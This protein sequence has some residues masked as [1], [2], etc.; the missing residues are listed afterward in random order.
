M[1]AKDCFG[2]NVSV[3]DRVRIVGFSDAFMVSLL[4]EDHA[5]ITGMIGGEFEVEE[6]DSSGQAWV[7][8][9][10]SVGE[11][12]TDGHGIGLAQS[13]MELVSRQTP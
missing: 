11:G 6:I 12:E 9:M 1:N 2:R 3:G 4:P 10:W 5:Q 7:S 8:I 13:E